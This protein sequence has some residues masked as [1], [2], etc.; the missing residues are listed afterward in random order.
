MSAAAESLGRLAGVAERV[1]R[2]AAGG[3]ELEPFRLPGREYD[4]LGR[5]VPRNPFRSKAGVVL[6]LRMGMA[7]KF[8]KRVPEDYVLGPWVLCVCGELQAVDVGEVVE[9]VGCCDR[10]FLS[11]GESVRVARWPREDIER[12]DVA[13]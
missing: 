4:A 12:E 5:Q 9:C 6:L 11:T 13:A 1:E 8:E 3:P 10:W 7:A 2:R